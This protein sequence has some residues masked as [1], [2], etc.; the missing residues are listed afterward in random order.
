GG[1]GVS[2]FHLGGGEGGEKVFLFCQK[3]FLKIF[4]IFFPFFFW[5]EKT[6]SFSFGIP[7]FSFSKKFF[8]FGVQN[9]LIG[10]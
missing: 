3:F 6:P 9:L 1:G 4:T 7:F 5:G 8:G 2:F 10:N